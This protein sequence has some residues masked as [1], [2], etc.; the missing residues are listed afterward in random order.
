MDR[1]HAAHREPENLIHLPA[2][3]SD[4][5]GTSRSEARKI[6]MQGGVF[7]DDMRYVDMDA[8]EDW[9]RGKELRVGKRRKVR[10]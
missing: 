9:L 5:F 8:P 10:L 2:L 6:L 3:I 1:R 7:I 4:R